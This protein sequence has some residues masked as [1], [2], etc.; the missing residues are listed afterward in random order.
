MDDFDPA[1]W[2]RR[3]AEEMPR[4]FAKPGRADLVVRAMLALEPELWHT[5]DGEAFASVVE[6]G[7]EDRAPAR[8]GGAAPPQ[9]HY[10]IASDEFTVVML[11][12]YKAADPIWMDGPDGGSLQMPTHTKSTLDS[13]SAVLIAMAA[14]GPTKTPAIRV[15]AFG[16]DI[17][18][19]LG[20]AS[21]RVVQVTRK[22]W[23]I[24][25]RCPVPFLRPPG[26]LAAAEPKRA[27]NV[28]GEV[29]RLFNLDGEQFQEL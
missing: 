15:A 23:K 17:W 25:N 22:G 7:D 1:E 2:A 11:E 19:D 3:L 6:G 8:E 12:A 5:D 16:G 10:R 4:P 14:R 26:M 21:H 18:Y 29:G 24:V 13:A 28:A 9:R 20:D 27:G